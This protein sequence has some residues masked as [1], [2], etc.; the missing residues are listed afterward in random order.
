LDNK[1]VRLGD[2]NIHSKGLAILFI[3]P[4]K[5]TADNLVGVVGG[6]DLAGMQL[7]NNLPYLYQG[8]ALPDFTVFNQETIGGGAKGILHTGFFDDKW[9]IDTMI[10]R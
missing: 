8:F 3:R 4:R 9:A 6:T 7:T 10:L 2:H 1:K 5:N